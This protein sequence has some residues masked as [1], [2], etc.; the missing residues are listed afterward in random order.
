MPRPTKPIIQVPVD[1]IPFEQQAADLLSQFPAVNDFISDSNDRQET[2]YNTP[3]GNG[4]VAVG[5]PI[6]SKT[7]YTPMRASADASGLVLAKTP[8]AGEIGETVRIKALNPDSRYR[9]YRRFSSTFDP[10]GVTFTANGSTTGDVRLYAVFTGA[11][12]MNVAGRDMLTISGTEPYC[13]YQPL[14]GPAL[15]NSLGL[16]GDIYSAYIVGLTLVHNA[17]ADGNTVAELG[18]NIA[19]FSSGNPFD[20]FRPENGY[21]SLVPGHA[22]HIFSFTDADG[23]SEISTERPL[24]TLKAT[25]INGETIRSYFYDGQIQTGSANAVYTQ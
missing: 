7:A 14:N 17:T 19:R 11:I 3:T 21:N 4:L 20:W 15:T 13:T 25:P 24:I 18:I 12:T 8:L 2:I 22:N 10:V 16:T 23:T 1:G 9:G 5:T 6:Q